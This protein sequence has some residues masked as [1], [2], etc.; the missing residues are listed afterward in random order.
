MSNDKPLTVEELIEIL[1]ST[2]SCYINVTHR[3]QQTINVT[4]LSSLFNLIVT[5]INLI[6][7]THSPYQNTTKR[8]NFTNS[9]GGI[10]YF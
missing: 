3:M 5:L 2:A 6:N 7:V 10:H 9:L 4:R 8:Q 1:G